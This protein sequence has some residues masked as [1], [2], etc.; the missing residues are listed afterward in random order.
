MTSSAVIADVVPLSERGKYQ[1]LIGALFGVSTV[2]GPLLGGLF[3]DHLSWRWAFYVNL[4]LGV[5][6]L[7]VGALALPGARSAARPRIDYGAFF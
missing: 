3:V 1:G 7:V 4:P 5:L 2:V 6:V